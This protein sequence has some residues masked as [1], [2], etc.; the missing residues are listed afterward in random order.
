M[1]VRQYQACVE[2][3]QTELDVTQAATTT[4][5]LERIRRRECV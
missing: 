4:Q 3:L 5:L 2:A 1:A